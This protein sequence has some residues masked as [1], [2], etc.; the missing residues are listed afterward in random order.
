M[1]QNEPNANLMPTMNMI[2]DQLHC[3]D[4]L[5]FSLLVSARVIHEHEHSCINYYLDVPIR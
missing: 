3:V 1:V 4:G 2:I 5:S